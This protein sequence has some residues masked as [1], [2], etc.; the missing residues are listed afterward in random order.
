MPEFT[1][2]HAHKVNHQAAGVYHAM[3]FYD[4]LIAVVCS[5]TRMSPG[6]SMHYDL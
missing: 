1:F 6:S 4:Y 3:M 2:C 5:T